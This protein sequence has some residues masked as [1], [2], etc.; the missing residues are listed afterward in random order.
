MPDKDSVTFGT[1]NADGTLT[2][3]RE[4]KQSSINRCPHVILVA[5]HYRADGSCRCDDADHSEMKQWGYR[6]NGYLWV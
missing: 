5:N 2:N 4:I 1:L 6:W 3:V